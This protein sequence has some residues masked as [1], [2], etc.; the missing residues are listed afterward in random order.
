MN[1]IN[2]IRALAVS[3]ALVGFLAVA[4]SVHA[5]APTLNDIY[6]SAELET[7]ATTAVTQVGPY[8]L[9]LFGILLIVGVAMALLGKAKRG[10]VAH[11]R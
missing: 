4:S 2:K 7:A 6:T 1:N 10:V 11:F 3:S 5:A 8:V 9:A